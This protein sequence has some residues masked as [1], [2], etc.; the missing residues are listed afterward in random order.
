MRHIISEQL[1][2]RENAGA[3]RRAGKHRGSEGAITGENGVGIET[4][5]RSKKTCKFS[6]EISLTLIPQRREGE[7]WARLRSQPE[8]IGLRGRR[9]SGGERIRRP[10]VIPHTDFACRSLICFVESSVHEGR[11]RGGTPRI[12]GEE[13]VI[14]CSPSSLPSF[15]SA[16]RPPMELVHPTCQSLFLPAF[17][18]TVVP[19][20]VF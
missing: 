18:S 5:A 6:R 11:G 20:E 16:I 15:S 3:E 10:R 9:R 2:F 12:K 17:L 8:K 4:N 14:V 1:L 13:N 19:R 7:A